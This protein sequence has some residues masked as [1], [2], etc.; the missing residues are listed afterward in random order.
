MTSQEESVRRDF[1]LR[2]FAVPSDA[3]CPTFVV[4]IESGAFDFEVLPRCC[5]KIEFGLVTAGQFAADAQ[6]TQTILD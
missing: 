2:H 3:D 6:F 5:R 4:R 1:L